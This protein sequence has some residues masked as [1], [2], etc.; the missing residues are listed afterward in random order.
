M[1]PDT[2]PKVGEPK[3]EPKAEVKP[4]VDPKIADLMKDPDKLREMLAD[5]AKVLDE[6]QKLQSDRIKAEKAKKD[7][8]DKV[9]QEQGQWKELAEKKEAEAAQ[10]K[11]ALAQSLIDFKI[12]IEAAQAGAVDSEDVKRLIDRS[13]VKLN[14]D[15]KTVEGAKEAVE[16]L[17][18][19]KPHLFKQVNSGVRGRTEGG[20]SLH[21]RLT[22]PDQGEDPMV[23]L[24]RGLTEKK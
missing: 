12:E 19:A 6:N 13:A 22:N 17:K 1:A 24:T 8:E 14:A 15:G 2:D 23:V 18:K 16:A 10:A 20:S 21:G 7:A 4:E 9:L 3:V 11:A 5:R